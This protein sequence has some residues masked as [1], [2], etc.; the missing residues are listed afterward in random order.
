MTAQEPCWHC[1]EGEEVPAAQPSFAAASYPPLVFLC[2]EY[3]T[4]HFS[5]CHRASLELVMI[6]LTNLQVDLV[7]SLKYK[8]N[9]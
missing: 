3:R 4:L 5:S 1:G 8:D 2:A 6:G 7:T 9:I